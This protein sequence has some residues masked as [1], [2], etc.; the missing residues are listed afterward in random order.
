M[1]K[2]Y[3]YVFSKESS[4]VKKPVSTCHRSSQV[5]NASRIKNYNNYYQF[6]MKVEGMKNHEHSY[7]S[8]PTSLITYIIH[9]RVFSMENLQ[10]YS[11]HLIAMNSLSSNMIPS[12]SRLIINLGCST[13]IS[14]MKLGT[15][16]YFKFPLPVHFDQNPPPLPPCIFRIHHTQEYVLVAPWRPPKT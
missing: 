11:K 6:I 3:R 13:L 12:S 8:F 7:H 1:R 16:L 5:V 4:P 10:L 9:A 15:T 2:W 14:I